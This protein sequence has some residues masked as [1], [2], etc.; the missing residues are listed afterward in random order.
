MSEQLSMFAPQIAPPPGMA[1]AMLEADFEVFWSDYPKRLNPAKADA[2]K[3]YKTARKHGSAAEILAGL[4]ACHF[5][6]DPTYVPMAATW[7]N[8]KRWQDAP[9]NL[10]ADPY[11]LGEFLATLPHEGLSAA[12]Y[13]RSV[14]EAIMSAAGWGPAWRGPLEALNAWCRDGY[15]PESICLTIAEAVGEQGGR[16]SLAAFDKLVRFRCRKVLP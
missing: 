16:T 12:S 8:Q 15:P 10:L 6:L 2:R 11:G 3:A 9:I 7:L 13:D 14:L 5:S 4:R 1:D